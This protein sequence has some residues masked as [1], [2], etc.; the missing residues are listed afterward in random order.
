M[1]NTLPLQWTLPLVLREA[2]GL[3]AAGPDHLYIHNDEKG[4]VYR[5]SMI[6]GSVTRT[7]SISWPSVEADFEGIATTPLGIYLVTSKGHLYQ[8]EPFDP[9]LSDQVVGARRI[10]TGLSKRCEFEG[11]H[12]LDGQLLMPCKDAYKKAYKKKLVVFAFDLESRQTSEYLSIPADNIDG[13][14]KFPSTAIDAT[15]DHLYVISENRLLLVD[16]QTMETE[17]IALKNKFHRQVEGLF[18]K[19]NGTIVLVEDNRKG[20]S[21]LT[22]YKNLEELVSLNSH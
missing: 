18:V 9:E 17:N 12:Y 10:K 6:D 22:R 20:I 11:L 1:I 7:A 19:E 15:R 16:R 14:S 2:S 8:M 4:D 3:A 5:V 13:M 21:R